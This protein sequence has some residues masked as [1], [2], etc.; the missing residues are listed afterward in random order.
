MNTETVAGQETGAIGTG[1]QGPLQCSVNV[2][3]NVCMNGW[4]NE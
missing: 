4:M 2:L 3:V 1:D